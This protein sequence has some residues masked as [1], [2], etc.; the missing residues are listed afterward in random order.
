M[1]RNILNYIVFII[2]L[3]II[4]SCDSQNN[5]ED[6]YATFTKG[7]I[8][9]KEYQHYVRGGSSFTV[10]IYNGTNRAQW[11]TVDES[12]YNKLQLKQEIEVL[13][14]TKTIYKNQKKKKV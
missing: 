4:I 3:C 14:I 10:F 2:T 6:N 5:A 8:L 1:K 13:T 11:Y 12:T 7:V 9:N